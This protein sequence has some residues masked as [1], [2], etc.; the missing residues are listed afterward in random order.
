MRKHVVTILKISVTLLALAFVFNRVDFADIWQRLLQA[1]PGWVLLGFVLVNSSLVVRALRWRLL[2]QSLRAPVRFWR[3]VE[4]Y[5]AANF[6]NSVLPSGFSGDVVRAVEV[7]QD[8]PAGTGA[9]TVIV[10]RATG[11]LALFMITLTALPFR[12]PSFDDGLAR[13]IAAVCIIGLVGGFVVLEGSLVR[14]FGRFVPEQLGGLWRKLDQVLAAVNACGWRAIWAAL[15]VSVVFNLMQISWFA[16]AG[17]AL[18]YEVDFIH[19]FLVIPVFSLAILMPSIGGL[20]IRES[21]APLLFLSAGLNT[22][23]AVALTLLV[24]AFERISG[25][26]GAPIYIVSVLRRN[27]TARQSDTF[28]G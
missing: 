1:K 6:F 14:R 11:L 13:Q 28:A 5:F 19:Y 7:A 21:V 23:Q 12:P 17:L 3:L 4:L 26:L 9:G 27:R 22:V 18:G 8:V 16:T 25:F 10:D 2:L 15:S 24:F 20:G